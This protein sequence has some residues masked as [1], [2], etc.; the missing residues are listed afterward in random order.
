MQK[1]ASN[2]QGTMPLPFLGS[3]KLTTKY[4]LNQK[5]YIRNIPHL[6]AFQLGF[7][8]RECL[9][10]HALSLS[11]NYLKTMDQLQLILRDS[12]DLKIIV[13]L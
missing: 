13:F 12:I 5:Y 6:S 8:R 9:C 11:S 10:D 2:G 3:L 4:K 7:L 1:Q